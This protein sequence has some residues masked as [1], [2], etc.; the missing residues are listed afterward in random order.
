M[1]PASKPAVVMD[2]GTGY[3]KMGFAGN[4]QVRPWAHLPSRQP[5]GQ[6]APLPLPLH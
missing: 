1:D 2:C 5:P 4:V 6:R 3:T